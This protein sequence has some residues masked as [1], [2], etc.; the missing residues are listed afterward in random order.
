MDIEERIWWAE[1]ARAAVRMAHK[2]LRSGE[3]LDF[4]DVNDIRRYTQKLGGS[5]AGDE[6]AEFCWTFSRPPV[7]GKDLWLA[8]RILTEHIA[9]LEE[10]LKGTPET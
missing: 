4:C 3:D 8:D 7:Y 9:D 5:E 10:A 1:K 6:I 2:K